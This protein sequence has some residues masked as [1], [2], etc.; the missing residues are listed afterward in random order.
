MNQTYQTVP[1]WLLV[2]ITKEF[3]NYMHHT[4]WY[5]FP[6]F[7]T[8]VVFWNAFYLSSKFTYKYCGFS[9]VFSPYTIMNLFIGL[10]MSIIFVILWILAIL[11]SVM[12]GNTEIDTVQAIIYNNDN[13]NITDIKNISVLKTS[14]KFSL[15]KLQRYIPFT[16][17][18]IQL[19]LKGIKF[20]EISGQNKIQIK[21]QSNQNYKFYNEMY[22]FKILDELP[23]EI[24]L[25]INIKDLSN[26]INNFSKQNIKITHIY[27][28]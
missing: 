17:S 16:N 11:P 27:D 18:I 5:V 22:R 7:K 14:G 20:V 12:Y 1:E 23:N 2:D 8:L 21:I 15:I 24:L 19:A 26:T 9:G 10:V 3:A 4:P 25:N 13:V 28:F 6:Y